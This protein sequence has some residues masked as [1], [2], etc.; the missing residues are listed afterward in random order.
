MGTLLLILAL[1]ATY[2]VL[3]R[4]KD[5]MAQYKCVP[6]D[7]LKDYVYGRLR[8]SN[9]QLQNQITSHLGVCEKCQKRMLTVDLHDKP[10]IEDHLI[11]EDD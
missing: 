8:R 4:L 5:I 2:S 9:P 6:D 7:T 10:N 1:A 3:I 11:G